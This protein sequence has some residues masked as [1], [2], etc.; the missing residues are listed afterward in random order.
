MRRQ[1]VDIELLTAPTSESTRLECWIS[2]L[3]LLSLI[4]VA[5]LIL[6]LFCAGCVPAASCKI[7]GTLVPVAGCPKSLTISE[8]G[9]DVPRY[10]TLFG[11]VVGLKLFD[12]CAKAIKS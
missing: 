2:S 4:I 9:L 1:L 7:Q 11:S 12:H 5:S 6:S 10:W 8:G 3:L